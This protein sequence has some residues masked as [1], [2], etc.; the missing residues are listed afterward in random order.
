MTNTDRTYEALSAVRAALPELDQALMP[1]ARRRWSQTD[2][3]ADQRERMD[4][5]ARAERADKAA[6]AGNFDETEDEP[7]SSD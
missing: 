3:S 7:S 2:L 1:G 4:A 6:N 5:L